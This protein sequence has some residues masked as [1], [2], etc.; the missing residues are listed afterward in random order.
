MCGITGFIDLKKCTGEE[1]LMRMRESLLHRGPDAGNQEIIVKNDFSLGLAHRRLSIIDTSILGNQPMGFKHLS[2]VFNGEIYN[3]KELQSKLITLGHEFKSQSDAEVAIHAF[4]EWGLDAVKLFNGMFAMALFND[5]TQELYLIKDRFGVKPLYYFL[6]TEVLLFGSELKAIIQHPSF[7]KKIN[8][9]NLWSFF[10]YGNIPAPGSIYLNTFKL[11][12]ATIISINCKTLNVNQEK[13]WDVQALYQASIRSISFEDAKV[14][15]KALLLNAFRQRLISDVPVG[16]F[17]SGGYDSATAAAL[18]SEEIKDLKTFTVAVPEV[19]LNE[20]PKA[21]QI[22]NLLGTAHTEITCG[23]DEALQVIPLLPS[24]YDEPFADS[25]A[26]P[27]Y[28]LAKHASGSVKVALSA[29]GGDE[30]FAGYNRHL[31]YYKVPSWVSWS[32]KILGSTIQRSVHYLGLKGITAQRIQKF[33]RVI[34]NFSAETY[35]QAMTTSMD[36][37]QLKKLLIGGA[38]PT[39][40]ALVSA[41]TPLNTLLLNDTLTYLPNDILHKVDRATMAVGLEGR[42]PFLDHELLAFLAQV[43]DEYKCN[44]KDTKRLLKSITHDYLPASLMQGPKMGFAI[45]I[46]SWMRSYLLE[47][48]RAFSDQVW[49]EKQGIFNANAIKKELDLFL[50]GNDANAL[51]IWYFYCF[52]SWYME[53][54]R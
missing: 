5:N 50:K 26:I 19:G 43:P 12:P 39:P 15:T 23:L 40:T 49:I 28:L 46:N 24:I 7:E 35:M 54:M 41:N 29:D 4:Y 11:E 51:F 13:Y 32:P 52:Q 33:S 21:K 1:V 30:L 18:L 36:D 14:Q 8:H 6:S 48:L 17:L 25:S 31:Y 47:E 37:L 34:G 42:E 45:P 16:L 27:T 53:W 10:Q 3:Y 9:Q 2:M 20:G 44:G 38:R 22:A